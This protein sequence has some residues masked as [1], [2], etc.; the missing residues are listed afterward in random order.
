MNKLRGWNT[1]RN[2]IFI[3]FMLVMIIVLVSIGIFTYNQVSVL[4]RNSAERHIKQIAVQTTGKLDALFQQL[5]SLMMQ[6]ATDNA[7]QRLLTNKLNGQTIQ[8]SERQA[9]QAD[10]RSYEAY[11]TGIRSLEIYT[12]DYQRL[13]PLD[14][15][16]LYERIPLSWV[17]EADAG[18]GRLVWYGL[19]PNDPTSVI[20]VR[21]IRLMNHSYRH[22]GYLMLRIDRNYFELSDS[23][24]SRGESDLSGEYMI[25][26]NAKGEEILSDF[27]VGSRSLSQAELAQSSIRIDDESYIEVMQQ[28]EITGWTIAMLTPEHYTTEGVSVLRTAIFISIGVGT[29]LF[30]ISSFLLSTMITRPIL[31]LIKAMRGARLGNLKPNPHTTSTMEITELNHTY[32]QMVDSL[33]EMIQVVYQKEIVQS[34]TELKALQAQINPH[35][36]F[37]TLEAFYWALDEKEETELADNVAAMSGL[38]RYVIHRNDG[39]EW[40]TLGDELDHAERYFKI[41]EMRLIDRLIWRIEASDE[42]RRVPIPKLLVQPLVENAIMHGVEKRNGQGTVVL[43][44]APSAR[45]GYTTITISDTGPGMD[46]DTLRTLEETLQMKGTLRADGNHTGIGLANVNRRLRLYYELPNL[47]L[48]MSS[49]VD[50]GTSISFEIPSDYVRRNQS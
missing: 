10:V 44:A 16:H 34:Q 5:D 31:N 11:A 39:E 28:S 32:N 18:K 50:Q 40:V 2:Q 48:Q 38:F 13:L 9:L 25:L 45:S 23:L 12:S 24:H 27:P 43:N 22:A 47:G 17:Q 7:V 21:S 6:V 15:V 1:L 49:Q 46:E 33:N 26:F 42:V 36:L 41:M 4:L 35:F 37:N 14:D 20:A 19:D 3:G 8:F 30:L 29:I